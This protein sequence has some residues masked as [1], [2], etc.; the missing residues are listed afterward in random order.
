MAA[1]GNL[2]D[3]TGSFR[4]TFL[5][6]LGFIGATYLTAGIAFYASP[7]GESNS[8]IGVTNRDAKAVQPGS[9]VNVVGGHASLGLPIPIRTGDT[10]GL[11]LASGSF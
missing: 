2:G 7:R 9:L 10:M 4:S 3:Q 8:V 11:S 6:T 1:I 5:W